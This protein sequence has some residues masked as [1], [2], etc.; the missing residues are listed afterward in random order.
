MVGGGWRVAL[1][2]GGWTWRTAKPTAPDAV[3]VTTGHVT[4]EQHAFV[5]SG[6]VLVVDGALGGDGCIPPCIRTATITGFYDPL[7][8]SWVA[9]PGPVNLFDEP[10]SGTVCVHQDRIVKHDLIQGVHAAVHQRRIGDGCIVW[11]GLPLSSWLA[12]HGD[13]L[14]PVAPWSAVTERASTVDK[15]G[16]SDAL[17][18]MVARAFTS[19]RMP[20]V[21]RAA[22]P[23]GARSVLTLRVDVD[24]AFGDRARRL[25]VACARAGLRATFLLNRELVEDAPGDLGTWLDDHD[26]GQHADVHDLYDTPEAD[27]HNLEAGAAWVRSVTGRRPIGFV[28]PRGMWSP[29]LESALAELGYRWSSD[30]GL[31]TEMRPFRPLGSVLQV[32]VHAYSPERAARWADETASPPPTPDGVTAHYLRHLDNQVERGRQVHIYGHPELLGRMADTVITAVADRADDLD[33]PRLTIDELATWWRVRES[34]GVQAT[35]HRDE[36]DICQVDIVRTDTGVDVSISLPEPS[37]VTLDGRRH[38]LPAGELVLD[39]SS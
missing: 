17:N 10:G 19:L 13:R 21:R 22:W 7:D 14:R 34:A 2:Q 16:V 11:T 1:E 9:A 27:F 24:G 30:F 28:A 26:V 33:L 6:G 35:W 4:S 32:P 15:A 38:S 25:G 8:G 31:A 3:R 5:S 23:G 37:I 12:A 29:S 36:D 20:L 18:S 39:S